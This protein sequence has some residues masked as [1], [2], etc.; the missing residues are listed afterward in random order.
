[1]FVVRMVRT[2]WFFNLK[3]DVINE[4]YYSIFCINIKSTEFKT[5][6]ALN[7]ISSKLPIGVGTIYNFGVI[8]YLKYYFLLKSKIFHPC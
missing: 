3:N 6:M 5:L 2:Q 4:W 7:V 8:N 1:M